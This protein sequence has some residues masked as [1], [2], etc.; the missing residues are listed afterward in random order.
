MVPLG[1]PTFYTFPT[2][3]DDDELLTQGPG[4]GRPSGASMQRID[5]PDCSAPVLTPIGVATLCTVRA[6]GNRWWL[7]VPEGVHSH[8]P[9]PA[10][11]L[12]VDNLSG[13]DFGADHR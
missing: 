1:L 13:A 4:T 2:L 8:V 3:D 9:R 11:G 5:N 12:E 6:L 10:P 7:L